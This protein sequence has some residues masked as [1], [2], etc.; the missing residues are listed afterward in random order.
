MVHGGTLICTKQRFNG[1]RS[2]EQLSVASKGI[3]STHSM[4]IMASFRIVRR[5]VHNDIIFH[6]M[7]L[8]L[9]R[10]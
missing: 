10:D 4:P 9:Y 8:N 7:V 1:L 5:Y 3:S 2:N 6:S